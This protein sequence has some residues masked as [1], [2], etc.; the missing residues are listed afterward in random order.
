MILDYKVMLQLL[1]LLPLL[2][3]FVIV[4][5]T[6]ITNIITITIHQSSSRKTLIHLILTLNHM[7]PDYD[8]STLRAEDFQKA[9]VGV[10][11]STHYTT[12]NKL[13]SSTITVNAHTTTTNNNMYMSKSLQGLT[14]SNN[15]T[16][17]PSSYHAMT[18][19]HDNTTTT[20]ANSISSVKERVNTMLN[21]AA[22]VWDNEGV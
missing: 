9:A 7:Y 6:Y 21:D 5:H 22:R 13:S 1:L 15:N 17:R 19:S 8:F 12:M 14:G 3:L 11:R 10:N 20:A 2:L 4:Y 16:S 18:T